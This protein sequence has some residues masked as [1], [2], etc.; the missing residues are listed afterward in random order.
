MEALDREVLSDAV[1]EETTE[2]SEPKS[3]AEEEDIL[4]NWRWILDILFFRISQEVGQG[5]VVLGHRAQH[6][7]GIRFN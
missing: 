3:A 6:G 2:D 5:M 7:C 1:V 4:Y